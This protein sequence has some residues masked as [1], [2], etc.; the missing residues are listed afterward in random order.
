[1]KGIIFDFNGT[2]FM[3]SDLHEAAWLDFCLLYTS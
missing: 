1:M 2:M 3:D